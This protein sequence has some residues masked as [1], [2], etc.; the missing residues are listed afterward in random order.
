MKVS[1]R[2]AKCKFLVES[3]DEFTPFVD[4]NMFPQG[5]RQETSNQVPNLPILLSSYDQCLRGRWTSRD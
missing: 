4:S 5:D 2:L 3:L 1:V